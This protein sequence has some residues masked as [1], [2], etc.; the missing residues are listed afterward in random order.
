MS[1]KKKTEKT[2]K[3]I[4]LTDQQWNKLAHAAL[5]LQIHLP[6]RSYDPSYGFWRTL[7]KFKWDFSRVWR[8]IQSKKEANSFFDGMTGEER[9]NLFSQLI[10]GQN[11]ET[12]IGC[13]DIVLDEL[14]INED[15]I[16]KVTNELVIQPLTEQV[17]Q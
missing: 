10:E 14:G 12:L 11:K 4:S 16:E 3:L 2:E 8:K 13:L 7:Y 1:I 5:D 9:L 15:K 17:E 6:F